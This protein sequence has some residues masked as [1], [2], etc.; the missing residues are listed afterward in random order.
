MSNLSN[1]VVFNPDAEALAGF[2]KAAMDAYKNYRK[3]AMKSAAFCYMVWWHSGSERA[4]DQQRA[5]LKQQIAD[6][7]AEIDRD[8]SELDARKNRVAAHKTGKAVLTGNELADHKAYLDYSEAQWTAATR[9][10]VAA[11][12]GAS[13]FTEIVKF[14]FDFD[15]TSDAS[16]ISRYSTVLEYIKARH[17]QLDDVTPDAV[18]QLLEDAGGFEAALEIARGNVDEDKKDPDR[19]SGDRDAKVAALKSAFSGTPLTTFAYAAKFAQDDFVFLLAKKQGSNLDVLG[20]LSLTDNEAKQMVLRADTDIIGNLDPLAEFAAQVASLSSL[21]HEGKDSAFTIDGTASGKKLKVART[22]ALC[23]DMSGTVQVQVSARYT[24]ASAVIIARPKTGIDIGTLT[25]GQFLMLPTDPVD[26]ANNS[27][28]MTKAL[29]SVGDRVSMTLEA[30]AGDSAAPVVW[31][32]MSRNG[33]SLAPVAEYKWGIMAAQKRYPVNV[34]R[35][36]PQFSVTLQKADVLHIQD[37]Y[38]SKWQKAG[39]DEKKTFLPLEL[40]YDGVE[41]ALDHEKHR[42]FGLTVD[43]TQTAT[44][45]L[46]L[47]PRDLSD[48]IEKLGAQKA[49][50]FTFKADPDGLLAVM[51]SDQYGDYE[52]Y[53]PTVDNTGSLKDRCLGHLVPSL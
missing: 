8:N 33:T 24:D 32:A 5:W 45:T 7:N 44:V 26:G 21:V 22:F 47:R 15:R 31:K 10:K 27:R 42:R 23:D 36:T 2:V 14:V 41:F 18:V 25:P 30:S 12:D 6:R 13:E 43:S 20:E 17:D 37:D 4:H 9:L 48:L 39:K 11:R 46:S 19:N 50:S 38:T 53:V 29:A 40:S 3:T 51:W 34:Y 49:Q 28:Q 52:V 35:F 16:N 1:Y